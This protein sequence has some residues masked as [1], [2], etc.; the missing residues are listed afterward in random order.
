MS[1]RTKAKSR[2]MGRVAASD[3]LGV[4]SQAMLLMMRDG[5]LPPDCLSC[6]RIA[7]HVNVLEAKRDEVRQ[8]LSEHY[9]DLVHKLITSD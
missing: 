2:F 4:S 8:W 1:E 9:P 3:Y 6:G 7:W 5:I